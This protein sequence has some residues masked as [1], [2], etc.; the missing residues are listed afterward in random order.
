LA[1]VAPGHGNSL[2]FDRSIDPEELEE[3]IE[4]LLTAEPRAVSFLSS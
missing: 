3:M 2:E 1:F 4:L